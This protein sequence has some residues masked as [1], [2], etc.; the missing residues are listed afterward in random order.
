MYGYVVA[1]ATLIVGLLSLAEE[2]LR[3]KVAKAYTYDS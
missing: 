3:I 2:Q 1:P